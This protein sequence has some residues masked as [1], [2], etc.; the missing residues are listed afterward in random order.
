M[1][2]DNSIVTLVSPDA[3]GNLE[4]RVEDIGS[5]HFDWSDVEHE[6]GNCNTVI[7]DLRRYFDLSPVLKT[8]N[9]AEALEDS[10]YD[11]ANDEGRPIEYGPTT[12][13]LT[14]PFIED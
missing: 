6:L 5:A 11:V 14:Q 1:S 13:T 7:E 10:L 3:D 2:A 4:Y 8:L 12:I 9:A